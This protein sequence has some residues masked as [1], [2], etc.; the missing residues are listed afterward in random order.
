MGPPMTR[1]DTDICVIGAGAGGLSVAAG[2]V[3]MGARVVLIEAGEMGGDCLNSGCVPSKSLLASAAAAADARGAANLG[4][5][6][7]APEVDFAGVTA[8]LRRAIAAIAPHDSEER[9]AALGVRVIRAHARFVAPDRVQAGDWQISARRFV[10]ATGSRPDIPDVPGLT[11][12]PYLTNET[13]F[14]L[15]ALPDHLVILGAGAIGVEM[16]QAFARLGA[17]VTLLARSTVLSRE[18]RDAARLITERL[19]AEG[20]VVVEGARPQSA[21]PDGAGIALTLDDGTKV[22]GSHLLVAT[23]RRPDTAGLGLEA[24]QVAHD[25]AGLRLSDTLRSVTNRRVY[26]VGDVAG[27]G[28]FTHL[29]GYHAGVVV[30]QVVLGL[31]ARLRRDHIP[32][33]TYT[34]PELA[35]I[36]P[37]LAEARQTHG[38]RV[39]MAEAPFAPNDRAV[40]QA[41]HAATPGFCRLILHRGRVIGATVV[42]PH[43]AEVLAPL[44]LAVSARMKLTAL[45]GMVLPYPTLA[46]VTKRAASAYF[47][48][49]LFDNPALRQ[50]VGLIQRF[51]P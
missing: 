36:G 38:P 45:T 22:A 2:A 25:A 42:G 44:S 34:D 43:A 41:G 17:R 1:I 21:A 26:G 40:T 9:F 51:I 16:A 23:G 46:E 7:P 47:S 29:A 13:I 31:P 37:T 6:L 30:R 19:R 33:A 50:V 5:T 18:D 15:T 39:Q 35:Q 24:G 8:H 28:Q 48:P 12:L 20:V 3:Q 32:R 14:S 27:R 11:A 49:K 10:V 4:I